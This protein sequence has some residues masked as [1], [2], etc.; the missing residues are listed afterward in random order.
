MTQKFHLYISIN[1]NI[2]MHMLQKGVYMCFQNHF[3]QIIYWLKIFQM[4]INRKVKNQ[5]S[6]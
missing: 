2:Q 3:I 1:Q 5:K 4:F 6:L